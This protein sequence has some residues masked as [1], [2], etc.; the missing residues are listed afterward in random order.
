MAKILTTKG[1]AAALED[2]IR[3]ADKTLYIISYSFIVS[4]SFIKRL[5][6]AVDKGVVINIVYGTNIKESSYVKLKE[7]PN[8]K[9]F[10]LEYLHAKI[11]AN[12]SKCIIG[13]MNFSEASEINNTE[14]GVMLTAQSDKEAFQDAINHCT[15]IVNEATL[16]RP[17]MPKEVADQIAKSKS[18]CVEFE[19]PLGYCI[20]T[21]KRI[22][23]NHE[24]PYSDKAFEA[25]REEGEKN[26][27]EKFDHFTGEKSN[28]VTTKEFPVLNKNWKA[29]QKIYA[30]RIS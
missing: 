8:M 21:G 14:L 15:D 26:W 28:G 7:L 11:F 24:K 25:W 1:S 10:Q 19:M 20:R 6:Q 18:N 4:D 29:Y 2:I 23:L 30:R 17:M 22:P 3:R 27:G 12:E 16:K 5:K 13:S 9:I